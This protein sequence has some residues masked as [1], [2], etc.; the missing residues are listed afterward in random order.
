VA[1]V[2]KPRVVALGGGH[3][4]SANLK[5]LRHV[6]DHLTGL[7]TV[8][9]D[10]GSSGRLRDELHCL[11]PGDLRMALAA[12]CDD[13]EWGRTWSAVLQT[14]FKSAGPL[15]N[16]AVGNLLIAGLWQ[17]FG[18]PIIGLDWIGRLLRA[19][20]RVLPIST[21][22]L[23]VSADVATSSGEIARITGQKHVAV[24]QERIVHLWLDPAAPP[25]CPEALHAVREA[26]WV[27]L[28]P[29]SWYTSVIVHLLVPELAQALHE[30]KAK[31]LLTLNLTAEGETQGLSAIDHLMV[32]REHAPDLRIDVVLADP[33]TL[34]DDPALRAVAREFGADLVVSEVA[35]SDGSPTHDS[36][37]LAAAYQDIFASHDSMAVN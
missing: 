17:K 21:V 28:G 5:A 16:H 25:A 19:R 15:D 7:V 12:L 1:V 2:S 3:G 31:R 34:D 8:A 11:P 33:S 37:R 30:T 32:L 14:R 36:L 13:G 18:D 24:S 22:P 27:I 6:S 4:L 10:G 26:D 23:T 20:G 35:A 29:G 9:D